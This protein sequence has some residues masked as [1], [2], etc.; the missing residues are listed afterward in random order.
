MEPYQESCCV[1]CTSP[2][3]TPSMHKAC[4]CNWGTVAPV[5]AALGSCLASRIHANAALRN[6]AVY[7]LELDADV[8]IASM[9]RADIDR[10]GPPGL[11]S[12]L[13]R[14]H[15]Q[16]DASPEDLKP[17]IANALLLSPVG[18]TLHGLVDLDVVLA[19][20]AEPAA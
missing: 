13:I 1:G 19:D 15:L 20:A 7:G 5:L 9:W 16:A 8:V 14:V 10:P 3:H 18:N 11:D 6:I 2:V 12:I 4:G 17:L